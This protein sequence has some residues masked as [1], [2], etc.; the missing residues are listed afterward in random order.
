[1][2]KGLICKVIELFDIFGS[3]GVLPMTV[4]KKD[5]EANSDLI[6]EILRDI[7]KI[8]D[9]IGKL[10]DS[11]SRI[12]AEVAFAYQPLAAACS[13]VLNS[14]VEIPIQIQGKY[15]EYDFSGKNLI[16]FLG[17]KL[18]IGLS[19]SD[20]I[21][22]A[23]DFIDFHIDKEKARII[24]NPAEI[25]LYFLIV[26][27]VIDEDAFKKDSFI[28]FSEFG[29]HVSR[30]HF[31]GAVDKARAASSPFLSPDSNVDGQGQVTCND[32]DDEIP[33]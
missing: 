30:F 16:A 8:Y 2:D 20:F 19:K 26:F 25:I 14:K 4:N 6:H 28:I 24:G 22:F 33:F 7:E 11:Q 31:A 21:I 17:P 29:R 32:L 12:R 23:N 27:D 18:I 9:R 10:E 5:I 15:H 3:E 1:V 13:L